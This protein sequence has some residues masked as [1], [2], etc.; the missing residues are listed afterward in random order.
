MK[1]LTFDQIKAQ[2]RLDDEQAQE[3][4]EL[5]EMYGEAAEDTVLNLCNRTITDIYEQYGMVPKALVQAALMLVAQSYQHREPSSPQNL[6]AVPYT[7]DL[8]LKP[9]M[10]LTT[11]SAI[12]N[13]NEYGRHCNL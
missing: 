7:Y 8:L 5:L 1:F 4:H 11:S 6:S 13:N 10:R 3:E 9:Y 12:N 2:L